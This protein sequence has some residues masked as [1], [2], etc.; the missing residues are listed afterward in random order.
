M[1]GSDRNPAAT[2]ALGPCDDMRAEVFVRTGSVGEPATITGT[3]AGPQ[4]G[5]DTTLP[6]TARLQPT[7]TPGLSRAILTE[8]AYWT[9]D[10]PN[11]Y[12]LRATVTAAVRSPH[13]ID[14]LVG[15]RRLG[16][17]GRSLWLD[18]HRW[19]PRAV[20]AA[21]VAGSDACK[22]AALAAL[23]AEP[24]E[25]TLARADAIGVA[26]LAVVTASAADHPT[27]IAD[28]IAAWSAHPSAILAILP[29]QMPA[30]TITAVAQAV[31]GRKDTLL[32]AVTVAGTHPPP[33]AVPPGIDALV[34]SLGDDDVPHAGWIMGPPAPVMAWRPA[35]SSP[36][37]GR[38]PCDALQA[39]LAGWRSASGEPR[40]WDWAGYIVG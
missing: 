10:L 6:V 12:R 40:P 36:A 28:R 14:S 27:T 8:P 20:A 11:L 5:R 38:A 23:V 25:A 32:L 37:T 4:R 39:A 19:V 9:P 7:G 3:L 31:R 35:K 24:D 22:P 17:R 26:V 21:G 30:A 2:L 16:V 13:E 29:A 1:T 33:T 18:G 34:V 15:L